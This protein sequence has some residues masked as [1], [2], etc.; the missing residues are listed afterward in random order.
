MRSVTRSSFVRLIRWAVQ[1]AAFVANEEELARNRCERDP[2]QPDRPM[3]DREIDRR[4]ER[5]RVRSY[6][7]RER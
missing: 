6:A 7:R 2:L 5:S 4:H 1:A 3:L